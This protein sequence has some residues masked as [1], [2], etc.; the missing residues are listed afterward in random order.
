MD[1]SGIFSEC[2]SKFNSA[3][4]QNFSALKS[5]CFQNGRLGTSSYPPQS[6]GFWA[7]TAFSCTHTL[8]GQLKACFKQAETM[9]GGGKT[10]IYDINPHNVV[11]F[12]ASCVAV[13]AVAHQSR[14]NPSFALRLA[15]LR[16]SRFGAFLVLDASRYCCSTHPQHIHTYV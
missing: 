1:H 16:S 14:A 9:S 4:S 2:M 13:C 10:H 5:G 3:K 7:H 8:T 6:S 12:D 11:I 15:R